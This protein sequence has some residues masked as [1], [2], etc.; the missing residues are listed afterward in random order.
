MRLFRGFRFGRRHLPMVVAQMV[1]VAL[2]YLLSFFLRF[3]YDFDAMPWESIGITLPAV[4]LVRMATLGWFNLY[5]GLWRY[6]GM[7]DVVQLTT[8]STVGTVILAPVLLF[9]FQ[10]QLVPRSVPLMDFVANLLLLGGARVAVRAAKGQNWRRHDSGTDEAAKRL[11]IIGAGDAG[12]ALV[13]HLYDTSRD[14]VDPVVFI[15]DDSTKFGSTIQ[16]IPITGPTDSLDDIVRELGI[17][18]V[19]IAVPSATPTERRTIIGR[20]QAAGVNF[21]VLPSTPAI[22]GGRVT[23]EMVRDVDPVDLL[24]RPPAKLDDALVAGFL[25]GKRV[26]VTGGAG[27]VGSEIAMQVAAHEPEHLLLVDLAESMLTL[28][29]NSLLSVIPGAVSVI[30]EDVSD[31]KAMLRLMRRFQPHVVIHAAAHKHVNLMEEAVPRAVKNNVGGTYAS[32]K[33]AIDAGVGQFVLISTDK[34]VQPTSVMGATKRASE[35]LVQELHDCGGTNFVSVRFGNVIGSSG[36]VVQ[37]FKEQ[38]ARGGPVT[39]TDADA[40]RYFMSVQE[41]AGLVLEAA[42][43]GADGGVFVLDM[44][45]PVRIVDLAEAMV[46]LSGLQVGKDVDIVFTG[47]RPGEKM[48]EDLT[49]SV[50]ELLATGH[51]KLWK[52]NDVPGTGGTVSQIEELCEAASAGEER[53]VMALLRK[54]V[55]DYAMPSSTGG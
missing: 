31:H 40:T 21:K 22:V 41:A 51:E 15:D 13:K 42:A 17:D 44:G 18:V 55:P 10:D 3:D 45:E 12:S 35:L 16:G 30:V 37:I 26:L 52:L 43:L 19:V 6:A 5:R 33:A 32:A 34:A 29:Q 1:L 24:G 25:K 47:L 39:V 11:A 50:E 46:A 8:A 2:S 54:V 23:F 49:S 27:S 20:C 38:L 48:N 9:G 14:Q 4:I 53:Q 7:L 36:S 28:L